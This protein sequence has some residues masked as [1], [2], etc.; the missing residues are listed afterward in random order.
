MIVRFVWGDLLM[1]I[2]DTI[3]ILLSFS[4]LSLSSPHP[5][6]ATQELCFFGFVMLYGRQPSHLTLELM[7]TG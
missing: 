6:V 7:R 5:F 3:I 4:S 1:N 2:T